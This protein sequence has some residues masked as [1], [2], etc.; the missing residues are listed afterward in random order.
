MLLSFFL[1]ISHL[2]TCIYTYI[3]TYYLH[4]RACIRDYASIYI[5]HC[6][7]NL[8]DSDR[9][10]VEFDHVHDL[11]GVVCVLLAHKLHEPVPLVGLR[12]AV[13]WHMDIHY[14]RKKEE[15]DGGSFTI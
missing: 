8:V 3:C 11:D 15:R 2:K 12:D 13:T 6:G 4:V 9:L 10:A 1:L 5:V 14:G 7:L